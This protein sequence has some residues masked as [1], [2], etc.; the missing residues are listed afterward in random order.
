MWLRKSGVTRTR[1]AC[2]RLLN[3]PDIFRSSLAELARSEMFTVTG[4]SQ[5]PILVHEKKYI[6]S[7]IVDSTDRNTRSEALKKHTNNLRFHV[8]GF[9]LDQRKIALSTHTNTS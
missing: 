1:Y 9:N 5:S 8:Q 4:S 7:V 2:Y 6:V 3:A